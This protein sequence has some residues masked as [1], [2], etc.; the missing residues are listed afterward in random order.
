MAGKDE[1]VFKQRRKEREE[2]RKADEVAS[3]KVAGAPAGYTGGAIP[4]SV[5]SMNEVAEQPKPAET[6]KAA[7][8]PSST[9]AAVNGTMQS[10]PAEGGRADMGASRDQRAAA[11][12]TTV[13]SGHAAM[14]QSPAATQ[15]QAQAQAPAAPPAA[16]TEAVEVT[17][18]PK[19]AR[20]T[21][22]VAAFDRAAQQPL[23]WSVSDD[24]RLQESAD[25]GATWAPVPVAKGVVFRAVSSVG[26]Q[27][28]AGGNTS[29]SGVVWHSADGG[30]SWKLQHKFAPTSD[31][32]SVQIA[33]VTF[34]DATHG[35]VIVT[36]SG[37]STPQTWTTSDGG[38]TWAP[39]LS[40]R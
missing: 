35:K 5:T 4:N 2:A 24:G 21:A 31:G 40:G 8:A 1:F 25:R 15:A 39:E 16:S 22:G 28:W 27:V 18:A 14:S 33:S 36:R 37:L 17:I 9:S 10:V 20:K 29:D 23:Q 19:A 13:M 26:P 12:P 34:T 6:A 32:S 30:K 3:A 7:G 38:A 11:A